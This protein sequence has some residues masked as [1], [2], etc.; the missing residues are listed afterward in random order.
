MNVERRSANVQLRS[1]NR[2]ERTIDF[3]A[4]TPAIDS[5]GTRIDQAGWDLEQFRKNPVM[6]WAHDDR[7]FTASGGRPIAKGEDIRVEDGKLR[8]KA[9][10]PKKGVFQFADEIFELAADGFINAV[11]VGFEPIEHE[12]VTEG[13]GDEQKTVRIYRRQRLLEVAIVTIP[14]NDEALAQRAKQLG[15]E[16]EIDALKQRMEKVERMAEQ[17]T[18]EEI[19]KWKG[20]FEKKQPVN[21]AASRAME[22]FFKVRGVEQ[23]ADELAAFTRMTEIIEEEASEKVTETAETTIEAAPVEQ[24][25]EETIETEATTEEAETPEQTSEETT[26]EPTEPPTV[27]EAPAPERKAYVQIPLADLPKLRNRIVDACVDSAM[28]ASRQG[29]PVKDWDGVID[30]T[31]RAFGKVICDS[32]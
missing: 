9:R 24:E 8:I 16:D 28:K 2:D 31:G 11:S 10:F 26:E 1:V 17:P 3:I 19:E 22:K 29:I 12:D 7:G 20:Y 6:T 5:Y 13:E 21:K 14:S 23:P 25:A 32:H 4:S 15:R 18:A 30:V 27:Q